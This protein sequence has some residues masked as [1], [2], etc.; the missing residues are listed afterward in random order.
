LR[1]W[2]VPQRRDE[3]NGNSTGGFYE[4]PT[5]DRGSSRAGRHS[6]RNFAFR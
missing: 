5:D 3:E 4:I 6:E 2:L 1:H